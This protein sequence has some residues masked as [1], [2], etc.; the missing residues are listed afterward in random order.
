ML[1]DDFGQSEGET[2]DEEV[3]GIASFLGD[4]IVDLTVRSMSKVVEQDT[5]SSKA[6]LSDFMNSEEDTSEEENSQQ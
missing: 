6:F 3:V 4:S 2:N 1:N 5:P